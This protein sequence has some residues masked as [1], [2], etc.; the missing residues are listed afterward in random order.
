MNPSHRSVCRLALCAALAGAL[1]S[2]DRQEKAAAEPHF[3]RGNTLLK[4]RRYREA[5]EEYAKAVEIDSRHRRAYYNW[6]LALER[7]GRHAEAGEKHAK[8]SE[9]GQRFGRRLG[10]ACCLVLVVLLVV[11]ALW[12]W[13]HLRGPGG[14]RLTGA[15]C[16][17]VLAS[18]V[19]ML[20]IGYPLMLWV[21]SWTS[22]WFQVL[23]VVVGV[24]VFEGGSVLLKAWGV[25]V[26]KTGEARGQY[27]KAV[28][29]TP[30]DAE[31]YSNWAMRL[32]NLGKLA[33][34]CEKF[35][36]AVEIN[37]RDA[38]AYSNWGVV[39]ASMGQH[40]QACL[41]FATAVEI[42]PRCALA[43]CNWGAALADIGRQAEAEEKWRTAAELDPELKPQ[44]EEMRKRF[45]GKE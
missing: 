2:C 41:K 21:G 20:G 32:A 45:L 22:V 35:A 11:A 17:L 26:W 40:A 5:C 12:V 14:K 19:G 44:I 13:R 15:G 43:Y 7:L 18:V 9:I 30:R 31:D 29:G 42:D 37:P 10:W 23:L 1:V 8:A 27:A 16:L 39:L 36:K 28:E 34:A 38:E 25:N 4:A 6:S 33:E 3:Q 24:G